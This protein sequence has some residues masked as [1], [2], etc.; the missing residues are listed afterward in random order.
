[1]TVDDPYDENRATPCVPWKSSRASL[2]SRQSVCQMGAPTPVGTQN[3]PV[4]TSLDHQ[5]ADRSE[6][7]RS[8]KLIET[9]T[10]TTGLE[11]LKYRDFA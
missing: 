7:G 4:D 10:I 2:E 3:A 6:T 1:M 11:A 5:S 9:K 8:S